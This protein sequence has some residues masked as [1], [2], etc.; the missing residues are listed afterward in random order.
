VERA[1]RVVVLEHGRIVE[2]GRHAELMAHDGYYA[3]LY[4]MQFKNAAIA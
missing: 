4:R 1:D 3:A 2:S